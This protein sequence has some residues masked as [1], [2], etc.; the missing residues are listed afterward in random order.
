[1]LPILLILPIAQTIP[2]PPSPPEEVVQTQQ[3]RPLPG[4]LDRIPT[5]N[6][7]S[8][9]KVLTEGILLS[10]FP[11]EGKKVPTAHL[12]YPFKGRFDIFAHHVAEA[13][14]PNDL[15]SLYL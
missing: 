1:M 10:T 12:N 9:E 6:S 8:P 2:L 4:K 5:F 13:P 3:V 15:R 14:T 11:G 7:N